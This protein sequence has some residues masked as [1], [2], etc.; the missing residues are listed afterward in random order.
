MPNRPRRRLIA[1]VARFAA[2]SVAGFATL[3]LL[4]ACGGG[5]STPHAPTTKPASSPTT[6]AASGSAATQTAAAQSAATAAAGSPAAKFVPALLQT[7]DVPSDIVLRP[8]KTQVLKPNDVIGLPTTGSGVQQLG[9]SQDQ[10]NFLTL[11]V[12]VPD[13]GGPQPMLDAFTQQQYLPALTG[14]AT[15]AKASDLG[16]PGA[17]AGARAFSYSGTATSPGGVAMPLHGETLAFIQGNVFVVIN[18]GTYV[19]DASLVDL[20]PMSATVAHRLAALPGAR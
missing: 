3:A 19:A 6:A 9:V 17:P 10:R 12:V 15:D 16:V 7:A 1:R 13:S 20:G 5:S 18:Y 11:I 2:L 8:E 14:N 4:G